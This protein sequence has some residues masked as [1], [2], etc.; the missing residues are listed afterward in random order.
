MNKRRNRTIL[1]AVLVGV[2][3][4]IVQ[5]MNVG[6]CSPELEDAINKEVSE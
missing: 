1:G 4:G 3:L 6:M 2:S 5:A